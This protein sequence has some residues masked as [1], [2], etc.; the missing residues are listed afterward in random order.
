MNE[1][2]YKILGAGNDEDAKKA[3]ETLIRIRELFSLI[4]NT[5][6]SDVVGTITCFYSPRPNVFGV[7]GRRE[8]PDIVIDAARQ[9]G[10]VATYEA[11]ISELERQ[12]ESAFPGRFV[13]LQ[14]IE[15]VPRVRDAGIRATPK[16]QQAV[17]EGMER[18]W[19]EVG[20]R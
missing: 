4:D 1:Q 14:P 11:F 5:D 13:K 18:R 7:G 10:D 6:E 3:L 2:Q 16:F 17:R 19:R 12:F 9:R 20:E 15:H 8:G